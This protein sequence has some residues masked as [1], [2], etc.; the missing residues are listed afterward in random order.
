MVE[1]ADFIE[2]METGDTQL[3]LKLLEVLQ[4]HF[5]LEFD[6]VMHP[7]NYMEEP[8]DEG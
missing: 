7:E 5:E 8:D 1:I 3:T 6:K 4:D 2:H